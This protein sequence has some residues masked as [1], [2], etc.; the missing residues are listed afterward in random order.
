M[1]HQGRQENHRYDENFHARGVFQQLTES[2][3]QHGPPYP[4]QTQS[5][6]EV[7]SI[8]PDVPVNVIFLLLFVGAGVGHM[9]LFQRNKN[10]GKKFVFSA[11][12][13][14]KCHESCDVFRKRY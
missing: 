9:V 11:L 13:F 8:V 2:R 4:P 1:L 5:L 12:V 10:A 7:P 6:G 3:Q 14:G